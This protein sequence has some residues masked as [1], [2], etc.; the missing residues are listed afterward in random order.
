MMHDDVTLYNFASTAAVEP[1]PMGAL[2]TDLVNMFS[3][4]H[5]TTEIDRAIGLGCIALSLEGGRCM[6][7]SLF[8]SQICFLHV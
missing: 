6:W 5:F 7:P 3:T 8:L 4:L 1:P 2:K